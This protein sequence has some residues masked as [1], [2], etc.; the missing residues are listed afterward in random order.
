[1]PKSFWEQNKNLIEPLAIVMALGGIFLSIPFPENEKARVAL[2]N[3][4][5]LWLIAICIATTIL[6]LKL[7][8]WAFRIEKRIEKKYEIDIRSTVTMAVLVF[9]ILLLGYTWSYLIN[10]YSNILLEL[11]PFFIILIFFFLSP[12]FS[13]FFT[14]LSNRFRNKKWQPIIYVL[15]FSLGIA[16]IGV[17][18][19]SIELVEEKEFQLALFWKTFVLKTITMF[20]YF[21]WILLLIILTEKDASFLKE[22]KIST[23]LGIVVIIL[24]A[25]LFFLALMCARRLL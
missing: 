22:K 16:L 8:F 25:F 17:T 13:Y 24:S 5:F 10:L 6:C 1:M 9:S 7:Y 12:I 21:P 23:R 2:L 20:M 18:L 11:T 14:R 15:D 3:V 4:K 19:A